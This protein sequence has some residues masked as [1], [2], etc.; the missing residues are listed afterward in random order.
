M[1]VI[2]NE[3]SKTVKGNIQILLNPQG[4]EIF[5]KVYRS[6]YGLI[7]IL[8]LFYTPFTV[9][10]NVWRSSSGTEPS[11]ITAGMQLSATFNNEG[12]ATSPTVEMSNYFSG[13]FSDS[14]NVESFSFGY[15]ADPHIYM[16]GWNTNG[17]VNSFNQ[18]KDNNVHFGV[19]NGDLGTGDTV[20]DQPQ[21]FKQA[22]DETIP[23]IPVVVQWGNHETDLGKKYWAD[24]IYPGAVNSLEGN[25]NE[26]Y[27]YYSFDYGKNA[28][29][30]LLDANIINSEDGTIPEEELLWLENDLQ[31]N[32]D[33][34]NFVFIHQPIE[35]STYDTPY[36]LLNN[37]GRLV[38]L[39]N[40]FD[41]KWIF[42]GH[43][44]YTLGVKAYGLNIIHGNGLVIVNSDG[45]VEVKDARDPTKDIE[46]YDY[47]EELA[48]DFSYENNQ[49]VKRVAEEKIRA[50][51]RSNAYIFSGGPLEHVQAE[52][53]ISPKTGLTMLK[54]HRDYG[55]ASDWPG[56]IKIKRI[57]QED[58][59]EIKKGMTLSYWVYMGDCAWDYFS[60]GVGLEQPLG[61]EVP[62]IV[63]QNG[64]SMYHN[65]LNGMADNGWYYREFDLTP[66]AGS[67]ITKFEFDATKPAGITRPAGKLDIYVDDI[68][69]IYPNNNSFDL[70]QDGVVN[71]QD[72]IFCINAVLDAESNS[73]GNADVNGDGAVN[74]MDVLAIVNEILL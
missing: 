53:G 65:T 15:I 29:F 49:L 45:T 1:D 70:N 73:G 17:L 71:V 26:Q 32:Q 56:F 3:Q 16:Y 50:K 36:Y 63:D 43:L 9:S 25:G 52:N 31:Q 57:L 10:G 7:M 51:L 60:I 40:K 35:Q 69:I 67:Y 24:A 62:E 8:I 21:V 28:H 42:H 47:D 23:N 48:S 33:K 68:K 74:V 14:S 58:I 4:K 22:I 55:E 5:V 66:L 20:T 37:R 41:V 27:I 46:W 19:V 13:I 12:I 38:G 72:V 11:S 18:W 61:Q 44:H 30:V 64:I 39:L 59:I 2:G 34:L 6:I 54:Y